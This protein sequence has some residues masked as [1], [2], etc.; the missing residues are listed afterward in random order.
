MVCEYVRSHTNWGLFF[1]IAEA[2]SQKQMAEN[3][4]LSSSVKFSAV[5]FTITRLTSSSRTLGLNIRYSLYKHTCLKITKLSLTDK[6]WQQESQNFTHYR[7]W[8]LPSSNRFF[9]ADATVGID[10]GHPVGSPTHTWSS[11][12]LCGYLQVS[13]FWERALSLWAFRDYRSP[14]LQWHPR[15]QAKVS[16]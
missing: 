7:T 3:C 12:G 4:C 8:E 6:K 11:T 9:Q 10:D 14:C 13:W 1:V 15:D 2:F 16:L 5:F